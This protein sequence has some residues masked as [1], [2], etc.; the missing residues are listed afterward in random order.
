MCLCDSKGA[1]FITCSGHT[2]SQINEKQRFCQEEKGGKGRG[3][4]RYLVCFSF[5]GRTWRILR[6]GSRAGPSS[7]CETWRGLGAGRSDFPPWPGPCFAS[8]AVW[9]SGSG[10]P[11]STWSSG[12]SHPASASGSS[13]P[14]WKRRQRKFRSMTK[15]SQTCTCSPLASAHNDFF[16]HLEAVLS[17]HFA[18]GGVRA[19]P[20]A[21]A[22]HQ[23]A[24]SLRGGEDIK[25][26]RQGALVVKVAEPQ[27]GAGELPLLVLVILQKPEKKRKKP[28]GT[29]RT[30]EC[31]N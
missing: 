18:L 4:E 15:N 28:P 2:A 14:G 19:D 6:S 1:E 21:H 20:L 23:V 29:V 9:T 25:R 10:E 13:T 8:S 11:G 16:S 22:G 7:R 26:R 3:R 31:E 5:S 27:F 12:S 24:D 30:Q 17:L